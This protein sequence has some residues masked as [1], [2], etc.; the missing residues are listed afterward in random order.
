MRRHAFTLIELLVVVAIIAILISILLPSLASARANAKRAVCAS[1]LRQI[2]LAIHTYAQDNQGLIP[3]GPDPLSPFDLYS[4]AMGTNML[5]MGDSAEEP[6]ATHPRTY[7]GQG[8]LLSTTCPQPKVL[9]CP[10]DGN[11]N[12]LD[13]L[14]HIGSAENA[15]GSYLYRELD[16]LPEGSLGALDSLGTNRFDQYAIPVEALA[17]DMNSLGEPPSQ[18]MNHGAKRANVLYRDGSVRDFVNRDD[19]LAIPASAFADFMRIPLAIDQIL[20]NADYAYRAGPPHQAP[21]L[22]V[23]AR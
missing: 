14:P 18:H 20:S 12:L 13:E 4:N 19:C 10:A 23:P 6:P 21:R 22:P 8:T 11:F 3:R 1:N 15:Y 5:W 2:G 17:L 7:F 9:F 16:R